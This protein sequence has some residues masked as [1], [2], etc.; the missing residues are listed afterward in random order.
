MNTATLTYADTLGKHNITLPPD[1]IADAE[2][3]VLTVGQFQGDVGIRPRPTIGRAELAGMAKVPAAGVEVVKGIHAHILDAYDGDVFW[4]QMD[5][6]LTI[7]VLHVPEGSVAMLT[8]T[9][10]HGSNAMGPGT[11]ELTGKREQAEIER[12]VAD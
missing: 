9:D 6:G 4:Q 12:R 7:G 8:H 5:D 2:V 10:E 1:L 3:P 11:Y